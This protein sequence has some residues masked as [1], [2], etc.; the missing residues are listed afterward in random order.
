VDRNEI[1]IAGTGGQGIVT[2]GRI[3]A[4]AAVLS[5]SNATHSQVYGPQSRG[6]ACRSDIVIANGD[7]GFPLADDI[8][9][10]VALTT[11]AYT[12]YRPELKAGGYLLVDSRCDPGLLNSSHLS[13]PIVDTA[14]LVSAN[15]VVIG[16]VSLGLIQAFTGVVDTEALSQ[17]VAARVPPVH[18]LMNHEALIAG[19]G[20]VKGR[21]A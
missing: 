6:G 20:L 5:G 8:D 4:E 14:R 2:A 12:R 13:F 19:M 1:R 11:K 18:R 7:V 3:L 16:V 21:A 17:A 10:L 15:Q 9:F